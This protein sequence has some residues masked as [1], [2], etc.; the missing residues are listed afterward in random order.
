MK[1]V[2]GILSPLGSLKKRLGPGALQ[3]KSMDVKTEARVGMSER[4]IGKAVDLIK[5]LY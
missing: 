1:E 4:I 5:D 3:I 2:E